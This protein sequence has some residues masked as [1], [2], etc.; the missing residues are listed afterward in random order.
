M[1][2]REEKVFQDK[3]DQ[4]A[5]VLFNQFEA[6]KAQ[7]NEESLV[8]EVFCLEGFEEEEVRDYGF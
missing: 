4:L 3:R 6:R 2:N 1:I 7:K 5:K 8:V